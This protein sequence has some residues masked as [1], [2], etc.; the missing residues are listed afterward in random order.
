[1]A[2]LSKRTDTRKTTFKVSYFLLDDCGRKKKTSRS[3]KNE[4]EASKL[5]NGTFST[6]YNRRLN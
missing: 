5:L 6:P 1:M 3:F 2:S 4:S